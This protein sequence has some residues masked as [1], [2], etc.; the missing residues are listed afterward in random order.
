MVLKTRHPVEAPPERPRGA[1]PQP[2]SRPLGIGRTVLD[3]LLADG[4]DARPIVL[5]DWS[6]RIATDF[7]QV[8][9][10]F[11]LLTAAVKSFTDT[12]LEELISAAV[13]R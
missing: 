6:A 10:R 8:E 13:S 2:V 9:E 7:A 12:D 4:P 3:E 5:T 1:A 11:R